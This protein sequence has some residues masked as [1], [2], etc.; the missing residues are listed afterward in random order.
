LYKEWPYTRLIT[1]DCG[2]TELAGLSKFSKE[3]GVEVMVLD[4]HKRGAVGEGVLEINP[5][6]GGADV[7]EHGYSTA[8]LAAMLIR[9]GMEK[10]P[11]L[12][13][14]LTG[15]E[16]LA[17][18]S[19]MA[20]SA[21]MLVQGARYCAKAFL[22]GA[23]SSDAGPG[24]RALI[25]VA[26]ITQSPTTT[27]I[28]FKVIPLINAAGRLRDADIIVALFQEED[29][30]VARDIAEKLKTINKKR[31]MLQESVQQQALSLYRE[32][33]RVL[34]ACHKDWHPG[35]VGPAAGQ[36]AELLGI[37]VF[38]GGFVPARKTFSFSGRSGNGTDIH[39]LLKVSVGDLPVHFGGHKV[40][41]GLKI[42]ESD[43]ECL[44][45][46][47]EALLKNAPKSTKPRAKIS[48]V[49]RPASMNLANWNELTKM[50]P[51]GVDNPSPLFCLPNVTLKMQL[52]PSIANS[53]KGVLTDETGHHI[54]VLIFRNA[55]LAGTRSFHG[56]VVGELVNSI[57]RN[58]NEM[59]FII[60]DI[61]PQVP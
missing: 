8:V 38:L 12:R 40:A 36:I 25:D 46:L 58:M 14:L 28:N 1:S 10:Y 49:L 24:V 30:S 15:A 59:Q 53:C 2:A 13:P 22:A 27:D 33:D 5:H 39:A 57:N 9:A 18:L 37:P 11:C 43:I 47:R 23:N 17:G 41:L 50:E 35:V 52:L 3:K 51:F 26:G 4:H 45:K 34:I 32:G 60:K 44:D 19:A 42:G 61:I 6:M 7:Q 54:P 21:S 56:H 29:P 48:K 20:D 16:I 31:R 55:K